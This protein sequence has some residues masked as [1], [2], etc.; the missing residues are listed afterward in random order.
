MMKL[1]ILPCAEKLELDY[2][3]FTTVQFEAANQTKL[4][5]GVEL[6]QK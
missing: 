4:P 2:T 6:V 1:P 3:L 5:H